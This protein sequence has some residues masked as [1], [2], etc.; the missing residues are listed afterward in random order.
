MT[1]AQDVVKRADQPGQGQSSQPGRSTSSLHPCDEW[2]WHAQKGG[3]DVWPHP[4]A[5]LMQNRFGEDSPP[6]FNPA[7][8]TVV[9]A[10]RPVQATLDGRLVM[11]HQP[12]TGN[13]RSINLVTCLSFSGRSRCLARLRVCPPATRERQGDALV[14]AAARSEGESPKSRE[15]AKHDHLWRVG[16]CDFWSGVFVGPQSGVSLPA[17]RR[18]RGGPG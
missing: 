6:V 3:V 7:R 14:D 5:N 16:A 11:S 9:I 1:I 15:L 8:H 17:D 4:E 12:C 13:K 2:V 18:S 10:G